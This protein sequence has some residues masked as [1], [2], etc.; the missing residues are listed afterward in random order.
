MTK[1]PWGRRCKDD[2]SHRYGDKSIM[3]A[4]EVPC[5]SGDQ[6]RLAGAGLRHGHR[7]AAR[8]DRIIE[9][10]GAEGAGKTTLA[11]LSM[12]SSLEHSPGARR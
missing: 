12:A 5:P 1:P 4:N 6:L 11:L 9:V 10:A 3:F 2:L 8:S 7:R